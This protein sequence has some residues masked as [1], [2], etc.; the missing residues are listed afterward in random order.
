MG[1]VV[2]DVYSDTPNNLVAS[3]A[4]SFTGGFHQSYT[5]DSADLLWFDWLWILSSFSADSC[6]LFTHILQGNFTG[7]GAIV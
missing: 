2:M 7:P 6:G 4:M 1:F 3:L 5:I